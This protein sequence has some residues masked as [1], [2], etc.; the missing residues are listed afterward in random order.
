MLLPLSR[1]MKL[2]S[3]RAADCKNS[4]ILHFKTPT[5]PAYW[6]TPVPRSVKYAAGGN[7]TIQEVLASIPD[8]RDLKNTIVLLK[9]PADPKRP[10]FLI[11]TLRSH[12]FPRGSWCAYLYHAKSIYS[13]D[14][15]LIGSLNLYLEP[16]QIAPWL[17]WRFLARQLRQLVDPSKH[18]RLRQH[19]GLLID[20]DLATILPLC[21][22]AG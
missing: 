14:Y 17:T 22:E 9:D 12:F 20:P 18:T 11:T 8:K 3:P 21:R 4:A 1:V 2:V 13:D 6:T 16:Y 10:S 19:E 7:L 15:R 5:K